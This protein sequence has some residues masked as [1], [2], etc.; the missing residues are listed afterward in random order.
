MKIS[1][2]RYLSFCFALTALPVYSY[3]EMRLSVRD[4][5]NNTTPNIQYQQMADKHQLSLGFGI[6]IGISLRAL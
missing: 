2:L 1:L 5:V 3:Y 6:P 4:F